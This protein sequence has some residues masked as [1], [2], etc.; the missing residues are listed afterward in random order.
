[1]LL[2]GLGVYVW[3]QYDGLDTSAIPVV[4]L[5]L[6]GQEI[7]T[8]ERT[9]YAPLFWGFLEKRL[10]DKQQGAALTVQNT[11]PRAALYAPDNTQ[12]VLTLLQN[13]EVLFAGT[14][15]EWNQSVSFTYKENG[16][17]LLRAEGKID[18]GKDGSGSF[19]INQPF[20]VA[21]PRPQPSLSLEPQRVEQG[22]MAVLRAQY[23]P[24]NT[25]LQVES[26]LTGITF[27]QNSQ[28]EWEAIV[29][30][31]Y[32]QSPG[33]YDIRVTAGEEQAV[34]ALT[35]E[36]R[37]FE[38]QQLEVDETITNDTW[39]S[40]AANWEFSQKVVPFYYTADSQIYWR[41]RFAL[42]LQ[43]EYKISTPFG[44]IRYINDDPSPARH[45]AWDFAV[46]LGTPV[47]AP[48]DG[49]VEVAEF[50]QL[51]G[52]T[53][54]IEY[55]GGL[56]SYFYHMN[57]LDVTP[58][59]LVKQGDKLGEVGTTGFSTGPHLHCEFKVGK[60]SIDP[61]PLFDGTSPILKGETEK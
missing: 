9:F 49:K 38:I 43:C 44:V 55:G 2:G 4:S 25:E 15:D 48:G 42:P 19:I 30:A 18:C 27:I 14:V 58:G 13:G 6:D 50:L 51:S 54:V 46:P 1:M 8:V 34:V 36:K 45:G 52:N 17:Y 53:V 40:A 20:H 7:N 41:K 57:S 37:D 59:Q 23:Y 35:V 11:A 5:Q 22:G 21:L 26:A 60:N 12:A 61:W 47:Y 28:D 39:D 29:P 16:A 56:K 32:M 24:E 10:T 3:L 31:G 33:E